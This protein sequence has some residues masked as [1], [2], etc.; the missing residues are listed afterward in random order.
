MLAMSLPVFEITTVDRFTVPQILAVQ[1][2]NTYFVLSSD[3]A[4]FVAPYIV[5]SV[6]DQVVLAVNPMRCPISLVSTFCSLVVSF[7]VPRIDVIFFYLPTQL[8]EL[9]PEPAAINLPKYLT[10]Y[11][12]VLRTTELRGEVLTGIPNR[13]ITIVFL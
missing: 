9:R 12:I 8:D 5:Q 3:G 11:D 2:E 6:N 4:Q 13:K 7:V 1:N 10:A